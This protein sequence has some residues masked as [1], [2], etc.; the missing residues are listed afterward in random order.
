M[1]IHSSCSRDT[2]RMGK[3]LASP[4]PSSLDSWSSR[5]STSVCSRL[6]SFSAAPPLAAFSSSASLSN[7]FSTAPPP[8]P[9]SVSCFPPAELSSGL[10]TAPHTTTLRMTPPRISKAPRQPNSCSSSSVMGAMRKVPNPDP[11]TARPVA[12]ARRFS[13]YCATL[14]MAGR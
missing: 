10:K 4:P 6:G 11:H 5:I 9:F 3:V 14:T 13:K 8:S 12:K 2:G 7:E 1:L